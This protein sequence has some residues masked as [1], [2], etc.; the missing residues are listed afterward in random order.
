MQVGEQPQWRRPPG[1]RRAVPKIQGDDA[2]EPQGN[3]SR[4]HTWAES[5]SEN[6]QVEDEQRIAVGRATKSKPR[7]L[8]PPNNQRQQ[9]SHQGWHQIPQALS[10]TASHHQC[11][12]SYIDAP[13]K[14]PGIQLQQIKPLRGVS[15][16]RAKEAPSCS[17]AAGGFKWPVFSLNDFETLD[18]SQRPVKSWMISLRKLRCNL[19]EF[20]KLRCNLLASLP[21]K[22]KAISNLHVWFFHWWM[23]IP[24]QRQFLPNESKR[25]FQKA[26]QANV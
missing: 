26:P 23:M 10:R 12:T 7:V 22:T 4:Y 18:L 21:K 20:R 9:L 25:Q 16:I 6:S 14:G 2:K 13:K 17:D 24:N 19:L 3:Q 8:G 15:L 1:V 5:R 11:Y